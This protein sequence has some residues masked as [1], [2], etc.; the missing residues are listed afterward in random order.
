M[1]SRVLLSI[2]LMAVLLMASCGPKEA[3]KVGFVGT[4]SGTNSEIGIAM[5]DGLLLKVDEL[6]TLGGINGQPI[7]LIIKDDNNDHELIKSI[8]QELAQF[9]E[10]SARTGQ[11]SAAQLGAAQENARLAAQTARF[12][13][14]QAS[15]AAA[16]RG[17]L[18]GTVAGG[19]IGGFGKS[20]FPSFDAEG[21]TGGARAG[22]GLR[23]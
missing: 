6:N 17:S 14:D 9:N 20:I 18:L 8:N 4:L 1:R 5:R 7:E 23:A 2:F 22:G 10:E 3:I 16:G 15:L 12:N 11:I 19:L 13:A 21:A